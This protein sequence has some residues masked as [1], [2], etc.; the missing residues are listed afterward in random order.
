MTTSDRGI[1]S[2]TKES[3][4]DII[5]KQ[6]KPMNL[7]DIFT[8]AGTTSFA[9]YASL[10][11]GAMDAR[12]IVMCPR[13]CFNLP[14]GV[15]DYRYLF[16]VDPYWSLMFS[17][18]IEET[19]SP[20]LAI[21]AIN[22][23]KARMDYMGWLSAYTE[24]Q[25]AAITMLITAQVPTRVSGFAIVMFIIGAQAMLFV[26]SAV[27]FRK[28]RNTVLNNAWMVVSQVSS[29]VETADILAQSGTMTDDQVGQHVVAER[30]R[31]FGG[32][33]AVDESSGQSRDVAKFV[34]RDG[35]FR[36]KIEHDGFRRRVGGRRV[37]V[38]GNSLS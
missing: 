23:A 34:A 31:G 26:I 27:Q 25:Q 3:I 30:E 4:H 11:L 15:S 14:D 5:E 8:K 32:E 16:T 21:Q 6:I 22:T 18:V 37:R 7:S 10:S 20:A 29:S 28:T 12:N 35:T 36:K 13:K 19:N 33:K 38:R 17:R 2:M 24:T 1:F 9:D